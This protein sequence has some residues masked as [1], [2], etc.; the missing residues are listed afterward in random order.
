MGMTSPVLGLRPG[1]GGLSR[2]VKLPKPDI[3][4]SS[5]FSKVLLISPKK[6]STNSLASRLLSPTRAKRI[7]VRPAVVGVF[8]GLLMESLRNVSECETVFELPSMIDSCIPQA[9]GEPRVFDCLEAKRAWQNFAHQYVP[10]LSKYQTSGMP[11]LRKAQDAGE[12][13][14]QGCR[15]P[16]DS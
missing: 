4:T 7:S 5:P 12:F 6:A 8:C 10:R 15:R 3:L 11:E 1:R 2:T 16:V 13:G 9:H 14:A